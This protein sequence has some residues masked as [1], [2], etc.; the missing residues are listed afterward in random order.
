M[1]VVTQEC[2]QKIGGGLDLELRGSCRIEW[3]EDL[4]VHVSTKDLD[5]K[6]RFDIPDFNQAKKKH[7]DNSVLLSNVVQAFIQAMQEIAE[8]K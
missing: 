3:E 2:P 4:T 7:Q 1:E 8:K 6:Y 5:V